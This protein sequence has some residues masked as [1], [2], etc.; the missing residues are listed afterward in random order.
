MSWEERRLVRRVD[1]LTTF[2]WE[3]QLP[4]TLR[5]W[6]SLYRDCFTCTMIPDHCPRHVTALVDSHKF[7]GSKLI[8]WIGMCCSSCKLAT[9]SVCLWSE[10]GNMA[11]A[12]HSSKPTVP[13][14]VTRWQDDSCK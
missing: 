1:S 5:A 12:L 6:P 10:N 2:I 9:L 4:G 13:C 14:L 11:I 3:P 7:V 8:T